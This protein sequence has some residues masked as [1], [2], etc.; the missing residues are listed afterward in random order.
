MLKNPILYLSAIFILIAA[1]VPGTPSGGQHHDEK[2]W[3]LDFYRK[4]NGKQPG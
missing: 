1:S 4:N 2:S 3:D